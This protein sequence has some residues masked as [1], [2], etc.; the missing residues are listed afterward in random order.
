MQKFHVHYLLGSIVKEDVISNILTSSGG[1]QS[2]QK[3]LALITPKQRAFLSGIHVGK[4]INLSTNSDFKHGLRL[5]LGTSIMSHYIIFNDESAST[6]QL[7]GDYGKG[8]D[9]LTRGITAEEFIGYQYINGRG[10]MNIFGGFSFVQGF[11]QNKRPADFDTRVRN[12]QKRLDLLS[13]FRV[14]FAI[15]LYEFGTADEV[16]Y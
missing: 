7:L 8:Y 11:T 2:Q 13:G 15:K 14:G 3:S 10:S 16:F 1:L 6:N 5:R 4:F 9:R 12:D